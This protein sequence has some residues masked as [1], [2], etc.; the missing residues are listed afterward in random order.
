VAEGNN[1][2]TNRPSQREQIADG[3]P[4]VVTE[5]KSIKVAVQDSDGNW[6]PVRVVHLLNANKKYEPSVSSIGDVFGEKTATFC[7]P[8]DKDSLKVTCRALF[9]K[10]LALGVLDVEDLRECVQSALDETEKGR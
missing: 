10:S 5:N 2:P 9:T 7:F 1:D 6:S 3:E 4:L 8:I